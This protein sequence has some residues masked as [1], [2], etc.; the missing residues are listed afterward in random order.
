ME[1]W[2]RTTGGFRYEE[3]PPLADAT[4]G[5]PLVDFVVRHRSGYCQHFA[6]TMAL[7]LRMLGIPSRVAVG[8]TSGK[9]DG[10]QWVV[11]D[12]NAHA[13]VE[14][15]FDG[16]GWLPFDPTPGR[17]SFSASYTLASDSADTV[18]ELGRGELLAVLPE[19]SLTGTP[20]EPTSPN[21]VAES[22]RGSPWPLVLAAALI[23]IPLALLVVGKAVRR[24]VRYLTR[25]PRRLAGAARAELV[26]VLRD[27]GVPVGAGIDAVGLRR[28][29]ERHLGVPTGAFVEAY[30]RA[31]YGPPAR[32][33]TA[34]R[35]MRG[36]LR[37]VLRVLREELGT[38]RRLR[39]A[40]SLRSLRRA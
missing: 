9:W 8:F 16:Y 26:D 2:L 23:A 34:A 18:R 28:A 13:W 37:T 20:S 24:R 7:M 12:V 14:A 22:E 3:R 39:G 5:P 6:G 35:E 25:D 10:K 19:G 36:E 31:R 38:P 40:L 29:V 30:T 21:P 17:G 11:S 15:W 27:Q 4:T 1:R 32:A 33:V